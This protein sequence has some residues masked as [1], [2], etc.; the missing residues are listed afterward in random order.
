MKF[1]RK[2]D[3]YCLWIEEAKTM[4]IWDENGEA[5]VD[6]KNKKAIKYLQEHGFMVAVP[7]AKVSPVTPNTTKK[8]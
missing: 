8:V 5:E 1:K 2:N 7:S 6:D 3:A 4:I